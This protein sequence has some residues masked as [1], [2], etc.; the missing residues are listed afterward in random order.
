MISFDKK[1]IFIHIPKTGGYAVKN[2][3]ESYSP[4]TISRGHP[5]LFS[6]DG[7]IRMRDARTGFETMHP[8]VQFYQEHYPAEFKEFT[9]F[10]ILRNPWDRLVS[11]VMWLN[12]GEF[13]RYKF[14]QSLNFRVNGWFG[15]PYDINQIYML[16]DD[17]GE[18]NIDKVF[19]YDNFKDTM[20]SFFNELE[21]DY[22]EHLDIKINSV[23]KEHYSSY[24]DDEMVELVAKKCNIEIDYFKFK[25]EEEQ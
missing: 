20:V 9:K 16:R 10:T 11:Y 3:L 1:I 23:N 18:V 25:F 14:I 24:Y 15:G 13:D 2:I 21:I 17:T 22:G 6:E 12:R 5:T 19:Y 4:D 8:N 7:G